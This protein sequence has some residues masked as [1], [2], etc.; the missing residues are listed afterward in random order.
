MYLNKDKLRVAAAKNKRRLIWAIV[1]TAFFALATFWAVIDY[2][3]LRKHLE[4]YAIFLVLGLALLAMAIADRRRLNTAQ[5]YAATLEGQHT[6]EV[7]VHQ[8]AENLNKSSDTAEKELRWLLNRE[9]LVGCRL[10]LDAA[11]RL[12]LE[13]Y[14]D[15]NADLVAVECPHCGATVRLHRGRSGKCEYCGG[16]VLGQTKE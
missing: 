13:H 6:P 7:P 2:D 8:L 5:I 15:P 16:A 1:L 14:R 12:I 10:A 3:G 11:P 9:L 4:V